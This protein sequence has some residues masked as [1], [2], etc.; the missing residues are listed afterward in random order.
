M[1]DWCI[2]IEEYTKVTSEVLHPQA[3]KKYLNEVK[4]ANKEWLKRQEAQ[5]HMEHYLGIHH[6]DTELKRS[7]GEFYNELKKV[8]GFSPMRWYS[9]N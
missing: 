3:Q 2:I 4:F 1:E 6:F 7:C 5:H 9:I 8:L